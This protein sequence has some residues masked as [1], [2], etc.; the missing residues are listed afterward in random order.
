MNLW[1]MEIIEFVV[2]FEKLLTVL[3][4]QVTTQVQVTFNLARTRTIFFAA[5]AEPFTIIISSSSLSYKRH[6]IYLHISDK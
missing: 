4:E 1:Q 3:M 5:T 6:S 2:S